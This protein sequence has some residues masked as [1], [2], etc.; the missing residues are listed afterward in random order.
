MKLPLY[1]LA[2]FGVQTSVKHF[3]TKA[4]NALIRYQ[5]VAELPINWSMDLN[6]LNLMPKHDCTK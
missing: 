5:R 3:A 1:Q 6:G 2:I 4:A